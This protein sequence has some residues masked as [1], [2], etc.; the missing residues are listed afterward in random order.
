T[1]MLPEYEDT[2][3]P[4]ESRQA[5]RDALAAEQIDTL[6]V[7]SE[8]YLA[9][10]DVTIVTR[11]GNLNAILPEEVDDFLAEHLLHGNVSADV[12]NRVLRPS[13]PEMVSL[14]QE[15]GETTGSGGIGGMIAGFILPYFLGILLVVTIFSSSGYL[16]RSVSEEKTS[17]VIEIVLS[18]VTA[19]ELLAGKVL[20][21]GA[22]GLTQ[23]AVWL[24]TA[25]ALSGGMIGLL[26]VAQPML[27]RPQLFIL[28]VVYYLL[29]YLIFAVL[30][31]AAGSLGTSDQES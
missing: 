15:T 29:G 13:V 16:L 20:G 25:F 14:A 10:G 3:A 4:Y 5:G 8:N 21:L 28:S 22:L 31:G 9:S 1:T 23:I 6:L 17:R 18:S 30:M 27:M 24:M 19:Q 2:F 12:A 7:I 26:G 11:D